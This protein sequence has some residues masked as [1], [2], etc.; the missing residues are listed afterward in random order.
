MMPGVPYK[1]KTPV[2]PSLLKP[3][4]MV[5]QFP[6]LR[7]S[8]IGAALLSNHSDMVDSSATA[9]RENAWL[10]DLGGT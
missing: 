7:W 4:A 1:S 10:S 5:Q 3:T 8:P 2:F 6:L 9:R